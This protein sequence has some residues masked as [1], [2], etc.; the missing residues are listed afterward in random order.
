MRTYQEFLEYI[1]ADEEWAQTHASLLREMHPRCEKRAQ[2]LDCEYCLD[3]DFPC[4]FPDSAFVAHEDG[5]IFFKENKI[6]A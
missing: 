3:G 6:K 1:G 4:Y 2:E 5:V